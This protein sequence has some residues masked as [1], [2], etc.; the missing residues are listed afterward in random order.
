MPYHIK[1]RFDNPINDNLEDESET[2]EKIDTVGTITYNK[3][4]FTK[5]QQSIYE[6]SN[7]YYLT[8]VRR[9]KRKYALLHHDKI[10]DLMPLAIRYCIK[11]AIFYEFQCCSLD[12]SSVSSTNTSNN[13]TPYIEEE[14][15]K[16]KREKSIRYWKEAYK[17]VIEYYTFLMESEVELRGNPGNNT[18]VR[19]R[20]KERSVD[21]MNNVRKV[22]RTYEENDSAKDSNNLEIQNEE[23]GERQHHTG[24]NKSDLPPPPSD[25]TPIQNGVEVALVYSP[26]SGSGGVTIGAKTPLKT[27]EK[28]GVEDGKDSSTLATHSDDMIHQCRAVADWLNVKLLLLIKSSDDIMSSEVVLNLT[29]QVKKHSH[30]FLSKPL[31]LSRQT[32]LG[33][34]DDKN[35]HVIDPEWYFWQYVVHQNQVLSVLMDQYID[36]PM[37]VLCTSFSID[38][39]H[40]LSPIKYHIAMGQSLLRLNLSIRND[41]KDCVSSLK[42]SQ[43]MEHSMND[44]SKGEN[45]QRFVGSLAPSEL[46][47]VLIEETARNHFGKIHALLFYRSP[48]FIGIHTSLCRSRT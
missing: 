23:I 25:S 37:I 28:D 15:E 2:L 40:H 29:N 24:E 12:K 21:A 10:C 31:S 46:S 47:S 20:K 1:P 35:R 38:V 22:H 17:H 8:Q 32:I 11:I 36:I 5:L 33:Q 16:I 9:F 30:V 39:Y 41:S 18:D 34:C 6:N 4:Q 3:K 26:K 13:D 42:E 19:K 7:L 27:G 45:R 14:E 43:N 44:M 48:F